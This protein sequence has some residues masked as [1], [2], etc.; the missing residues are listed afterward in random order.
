MMEW[1]RLICDKRLGKEEEQ[2]E[3]RG[4]ISGIGRRSEF[5]RDYDRLIFSA[6]FRRLQNKAQIFPLP[7]N[8]FVHNR[9]T[10][11]LEVSCVGRSLGNL[12]GGALAAKYPSLPFSSGDLAA[13]VSAACLAH[14][15]G[16]P[17]F[18]HSGERAISAY[19]REG[20]G[21]KWEKEVR[22]EGGRWEDFTTFDGNANTF[23]LLTHRF[24]GRRPGGF[25]LS[26]STLAAIVKYPYPSVSSLKA[27]KFGF[28]AT[29]EDTYRQLADCLGICCKD[30]ARRI[31]ARHPLV[32]LVE[33]ADD[34]C[35]E[36]MDL[37]DAFKLRILSLAE[38]EALLIDFF[39]EQEGNRLAQKAHAI[40]DDN[41]RVAYLRS[42][43]INVLI[44][45]CAT[46]FVTHEEE[47]MKGIFRG[48]LIEHCSAR[49]LAAYRKAEKIAYG[50]IYTSRDV[51]DVELA[52]H[53]IF[54]EIIERTM[55]AL[56]HP[57]NAYSRTFLSRVS[58]QY[59]RK[60]SST[61]E[62]ILTT[63]DY[64]SGMTDLY[65]LELYRKIT[66]M[67]LPHV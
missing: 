24:V 65:A 6:P 54:A 29:E 2:G 58:S 18:G 52:G 67:S 38:V 40:E 47:I 66:G 37:E 53:R 30:A 57:D 31:Y 20:E 44:A 7:G 1:A 35:Y 14:D 19:F 5:E 28:F 46:A 51:V 61:Y 63:L 50:R 39:D 42:K 64:I 12:A 10:H 33:A 34:I 62:R 49:S 32:Y 26:Y 36:I 25:G 23:R 11:T 16:N 3:L 43:V 22:N 55:Y 4:T 27:G 59:D 56:E 8:V 9:L 41:E 45:D 17:P 15:L 60:A 13:I 48:S 21:R